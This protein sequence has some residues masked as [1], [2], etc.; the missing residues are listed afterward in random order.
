MKRKK[1]KI[2]TENLVQINESSKKIKNYKNNTD[3]ICAANVI[4]HMPDLKNLI[5]NKK[6]EIYDEVTR[7]HRNFIQLGTDLCLFLSV[8]NGTDLYRFNGQKHR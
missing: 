3:V 4:A 7:A 1:Q 5:E 8:Q 6:K 2:T